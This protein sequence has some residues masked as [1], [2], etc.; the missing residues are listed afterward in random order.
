MLFCLSLSGKGLGG[1]ELLSW[2]IG[3]VE[4]LV[5]TNEASRIALEP[6]KKPLAG[7]GQGGFAAGN[8][9]SH[10]SGSTTSWRGTLE[11]G[12]ARSCNHPSSQVNIL[13]TPAHISIIH[14]SLSQS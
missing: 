14:V 3:A 7:P 2:R 9:G 10:I 8:R 1:S 4:S 6:W 12:E 5:S 11:S 13:Q